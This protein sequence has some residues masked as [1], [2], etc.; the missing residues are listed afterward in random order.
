MTIHGDH[1]FLPAES[2]RSPVRRFR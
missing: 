2:D 1:P